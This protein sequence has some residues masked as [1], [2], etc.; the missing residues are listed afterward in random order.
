[1][2]NFSKYSDNELLILIQGPNPICDQAFNE[3]I[4]RHSAKLS[5]YCL[6][7]TTSKF[8]TQETLQETWIN[9]FIAIKSGSKIRS[10]QQ[11]L[12]QVAN[13]IVLQKSRSNK[14]TFVTDEEFDLTKIPDLN[15][16]LKILERDEL[17]AHV[18]SAIAFLDDIYKEPFLMFWF[19]EL[20]F[21]EIAEITG[22]SI[23]CIKKRCY[24]ATEKVIAFL[25]PVIEDMYKR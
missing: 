22:D 18:S 12:Y 9:F 4:N 1:M 20:S 13:N 8:D 11:Y 15:D 19:S 5:S 21:P 17:L 2:V 25:K 7:K 6:H 16:A 14:I 3:L 23:D 24:R 10:I